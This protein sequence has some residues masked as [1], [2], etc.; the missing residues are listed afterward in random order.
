MRLTTEASVVLQSPAPNECSFGEQGQELAF[1]IPKFPASGPPKSSSNS[2]NTRQ[3]MSGLS[4]PIRKSS[5][6]ALQQPL[7]LF[8]IHRACYLR[9]MID[10]CTTNHFVLRSSFWAEDKGMNVVVISSPFC[11]APKNPGRSPMAND[12]CFDDRDGDTKQ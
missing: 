5:P 1:E 10:Q 3:H 11:K 4:V 7:C 2:A 6:V 9:S 8:I 12:N